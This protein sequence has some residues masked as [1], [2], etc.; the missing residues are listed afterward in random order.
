MPLRAEIVARVGHLRFGLDGRIRVDVEAW[1]REAERLGM[2]AAW[3]AE[4]VRHGYPEVPIWISAVP[5]FHEAG[6]LARG[7]P[8]ICCGAGPEEHC[9][10]ELLPLSDRKNKDG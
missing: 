8:C 5:R 4:W 3:A 10:H 1:A 2:D 6:R 7:V 9:R